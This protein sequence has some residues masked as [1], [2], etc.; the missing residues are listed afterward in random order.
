MSDEHTDLDQVVGALNR[1]AERVQ[2]LWFAF[3]TVTLYF[4]ATVGS[5]THRMIFLQ[6]G[7]TLPLVG[8]NLPLVGFYIVGPLIYVVMHAYVLM[9][10]ILLARTAKTFELTLDRAKLSG[11]TVAQTEQHRMRLENAIF[12]QIIVGARRERT[13]LNGFVLRIIALAT[14]AVGPALLLLMFQLMFLPYQED[15]VTWLHRALVV[16]DVLMVWMLWPSYAYRWGESV[17]PGGHGRRAL[18]LRTLA[19]SLVAAF[20]IFFATHSDEWWRNNFAATGINRAT[21]WAQIDAHDRDERSGSA[22]TFLFGGKGARGLFPN[23]LWLQDERFTEESK[24]E[25]F[26]KVLRDGAQSTGSTQSVR[27][28]NLANAWFV[29]ADL[30]FVDFTLARLK[31]AAFNGAQIEGAQFQG[32]NLDHSTFNR[33]VANS[34]SFDLAEAQAADFS[35]AILQAA[36]FR[37]TKLQQASLAYTDLRGA[38]LAGAVLLGA[39]SYKVKIDGANLDFAYWP[40]AQISADSFVGTS[41][42]DGVLDA[43][44]FRDANMMASDLSRASLM[45]AD[46]EN[47]NLAGALIEGVRVWRVTGKP[48]LEGALLHNVKVDSRAAG[49]ASSSTYNPAISRLSVRSK[50]SFDS[51]LSEVVSEIPEEA[52]TQSIRGENFGMR[53]YFYPDDGSLRTAIRTSLL[54]LDPERPAILNGPLDEEWQKR[55]DMETYH[56]ALKESACSSNSA[57]FVARSLI[58]S[59]LAG[60]GDCG[61]EGDTSRLSGIDAALARRLAR[62]MRE[63]A[64]ASLSQELECPGG[65]GLTTRD[66][67]RLNEIVA[68]SKSKR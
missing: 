42:R 40:A 18:V 64:A 23:R 59:R 66:L 45:G 34:A 36:S 35:S 57:P 29:G 6:T 48:Q 5:T 11:M 58:D 4:A 8:V 63:A 24:V 7:L 37:G 28:R 51:S 61:E 9:M 54:V 3:L 16:F 39:A 32:S 19:A 44:T 13:G 30:R 52:R 65:Y 68:E 62:L 56:R 27:G 53:G 22:L 26:R 55:T 60:R 17:I 2:T 20:S 46:L 10:L 12:L 15:Y 33:A 25:E 67:K 1:S 49:I 47:T 14:L 43:A 50:G 38:C 31:G 41:F 21:G